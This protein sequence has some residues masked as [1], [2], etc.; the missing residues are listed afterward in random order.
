L[1][2]LGYKVYFF[3]IHIVVAG[4]Q[5][6]PITRKILWQRRPE[7]LVQPISRQSILLGNAGK[8]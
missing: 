4:R 6:Q 2:G 3:A 7:L 1:D 5:Q 8:R